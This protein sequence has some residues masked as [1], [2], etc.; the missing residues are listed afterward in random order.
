MKN[1][2]FNYFSCKNSTRDSASSSAKSCL[3]SEIKGSTTEH[4]F[5]YCKDEVILISSGEENDSVPSKKRKSLKVRKISSSSLPKRKSNAPFSQ[6]QKK[7]TLEEVLSNS[8]LTDESCDSLVQQNDATALITSSTPHELPYYLRNFRLAIDTVMNDACD[9]KLFE[10]E[11]AR[12]IQSFYK[13][14]IA[15][16]KLYT[17]L[18]HRKP[19]WLP[20]NKVRQ[21]RK[22]TVKYCFGSCFSNLYPLF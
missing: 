18:F 17:R 22:L 8:G 13:L 1:T 4:S 12:W 2:I 16:Q 20:I 9:A 21:H 10:G 19:A 6:K 5:S 7:E 11:D 3:S 15:C 14:P